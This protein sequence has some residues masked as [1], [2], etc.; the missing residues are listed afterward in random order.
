MIPNLS[1]ELG[2]N[3]VMPYSIVKCVTLSYVLININ[4]SN[5][6]QH[7]YRLTINMLICRRKRSAKNSRSLELWSKKKPQLGFG[8]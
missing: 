3:N 2:H 8:L 5:D 4:I 6:R 7:I 1:P